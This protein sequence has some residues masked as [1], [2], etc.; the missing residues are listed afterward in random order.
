R[1]S[2]GTARGGAGVAATRAVRVT[3]RV[4]VPTPG[5]A[6]APATR[7][8]RGCSPAARG[9]D[10][11]AVGDAGAASPGAVTPVGADVPAC[12]GFAGMTAA[13][14]DVGL[15]GARVGSVCAP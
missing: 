3:T 14:A 10:S 11:V 12:A 8:E 6:E 2:S 1:G 5:A 9:F 7:V 4:S 15:A 13:R